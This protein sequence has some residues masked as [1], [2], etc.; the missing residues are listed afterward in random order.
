MAD[1]YADIIVD[2]SHEKVDRPFQYCVPE[3][4][5]EQVEVGCCVQVPFGKGNKSSYAVVFEFSDST[6]FSGVKSV[7]D[8]IPDIYLNDEMRKL[9]QFLK[10]RTFCSI[11]DAV[12]S[13]VPVAAF[14]KMYSL[15]SLADNVDID[16]FAENAKNI[17]LYLKEQC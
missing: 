7:I 10:D 12:K 5:Q 14:G 1:M 16:S 6:E 13:A 17:C 2:I 9:C 3:S 4:L 8:V 11:G 15:Y